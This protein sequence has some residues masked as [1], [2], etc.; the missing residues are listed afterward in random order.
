MLLKEFI[1]NLNKIVEEDPSLLDLPVF[2][3][4]D[5]E[6]NGFNSV[7]FSPTCL[8]ASKNSLGSLDY[9]INTAYVEE[10][11]KTVL[12]GDYILRKDYLTDEEYEIAVQN[13]IKDYSVKFIVIN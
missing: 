5:E 1:D 11:L 13:H 6:G 10:E 2:A 4:I 12:V 7:D 3:A 8:Y 9:Y